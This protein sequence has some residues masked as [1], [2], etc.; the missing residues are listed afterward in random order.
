MN[1]SYV[2]LKASSSFFFVLPPLK[3]M[4]QWS[5]WEHNNAGLNEERRVFSV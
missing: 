2:R 5:G 3:T 1:F 4:E